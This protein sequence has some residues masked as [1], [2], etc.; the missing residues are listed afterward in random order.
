LS[1]PFVSRGL[2]VSAHVLAAFHP[3]VAAHL[4]LHLGCYPQHLVSPWTSYAA[5]FVVCPEDTCPKFFLK[6]RRHN[7]CVISCRGQ[8]RASQHILSIAPESHWKKQFSGLSWSYLVNPAA[9]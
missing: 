6:V 4:A 7:P 8:T 1:L 9:R 2:D 5:P 3:L